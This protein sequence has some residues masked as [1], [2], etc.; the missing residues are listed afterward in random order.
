M[1]VMINRDTFSKNRLIQLLEEMDI[2]SH[3]ET[4]DSVVERLKADQLSAKA[5]KGILLARVRSLSKHMYDLEQFL[6]EIDKL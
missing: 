2:S 3:K 4:I 5:G 6:K 1:E